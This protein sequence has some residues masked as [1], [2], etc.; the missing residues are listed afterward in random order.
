M[1]CVKPSIFNLLATLIASVSFAEVNRCETLFPNI[2]EGIRITKA[3]DLESPALVTLTEAKASESAQA[4]AIKIV[5]QALVS[6]SFILSDKNFISKD[7][8][9]IGYTIDNGYTLSVIYKSDSRIENRFIINELNL[10]TP[11]N[12][13]VKLSDGLFKEDRFELNKNEFEVNNYFPL[14]TKIEANVPFFIE[15]STLEVLDHYNTYFNLFKKEELKK[16]FAASS[17]KKIQSL[18][19]IRRAKDVFRKVLIK[20]PYK[21]IIGVAVSFAA[22]TYNNTTTI[23]DPKPLKIAPETTLKTANGVSFGE[24]IPDPK[25]GKIIPYK[26]AAEEYKNSE[27]IEYKIQPV[28]DSVFEELERNSVL[29]NDLQRSGLQD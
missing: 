22:L 23:T 20:Q 9:S 14:G 6:P 16:I 28:S 25:T 5:R 17:S 1:N 4:Q 11:T 13:K 7:E 15:A 12:Y 8:I 2:Q 29:E 26:I 3:I 19:S 24:K 27:M 10:I 21:M 18:L